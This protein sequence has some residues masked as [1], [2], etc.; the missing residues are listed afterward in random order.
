MNI[1]QTAGYWYLA[2]P[3]SR[4]PGGI[5]N[6]YWEACKVAGWLIKRG[7]P[8]YCPIAETH[9][10]AVH[11]GVDPLDHELWIRADRPKMDAAAGLI[12]ATL[13]TWETSRGVLEE[14]AIFRAAG[15]PI[16]FLDWELKE[17]RWT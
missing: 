12:V 3:Y 6:A 17:I 15:K 10:I 5:W 9:G 13:P 16:G 14:I 2:T 4:F 11:G 1:P 7:V 8:V